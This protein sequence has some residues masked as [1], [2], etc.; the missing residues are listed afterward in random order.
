MSHRPRPMNHKGGEIL[1]ARIDTATSR[2]VADI[3]TAKEIAGLLDKSYPGHLW[4]VHVD[5]LGGIATVKNMRLSGTWGFM[6][7]LT[8]TFS[9]SEFDKR[10]KM[11]GG[12]LLERYRLHTGAFRQSQY[13]GIM[14]PTG[15]L[16]AQL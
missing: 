3:T 8:D 9:G 10:V 5:S 15:Q 6:L 13:D 2:D 12:E 4:A 7:K 16:V 11:A 14:T 1:A